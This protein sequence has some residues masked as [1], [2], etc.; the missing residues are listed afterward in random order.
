MISSR[1][2]VAVLALGDMYE[3][4]GK[5]VAEKLGASLVNPISANILDT[6]SLDKLADENKVIVTLEDNILDGGFG[7]K[8]V[9]YLGDKD[10]KVLNYGQN[11]FTLIKFH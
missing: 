11:V 9:S 1:N 6:A 3:M 10:V 8:V 2:D 7:E 4:L 5:E